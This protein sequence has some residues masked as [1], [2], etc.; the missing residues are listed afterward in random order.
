MQMTLNLSIGR[1]LAVTMMLAASA[2]TARAQQPARVLPDAQIAAHVMHRLA[3]KQI[4][5]VEVSVS[6]QVVTLT[7]QVPS[8]WAEQQAIDT[9]R[10][11]DDVRQ[12]VNRM[13]VMRAESDKIVAHDVARQIRHYVFYTIFDNVDI[14]VSNGDVVLTGAVTQ[15]WRSAEIANL[16]TRVPGVQEVSNKITTLPVSQFDDQLRYRLASKIY[17]NPQFWNYA[18]GSNPPIHIVVDN[19]HVT[20][21]GAVGSRMD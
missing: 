13:H 17:G 21:A 9:S 8:L 18:I 3:E 14:A 1:V 16:V 19:G 2:A 4:G 12:V 15:P 6:N 5:G 20:L 11:A 7:G 10:K